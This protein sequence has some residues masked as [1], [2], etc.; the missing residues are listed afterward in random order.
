MSTEQKDIFMT[1]ELPANFRELPNTRPAFRQVLTEEFSS[2]HASIR[3]RVAQ[4]TQGLRLNIEYG[5][6]AAFADNGNPVI[7]QHATPFA[8]IESWAD[9]PLAS[10]SILNY[11]KPRVGITDI[12]SSGRAVNDPEFNKAFAR[13]ALAHEIIGHESD[14]ATTGNIHMFSDEALVKKNGWQFSRSDLF[15]KTLKEE[16]QKNVDSG[17]LASVSKYIRPAVD[18]GGNILPDSLRKVSA[19]FYADAAAY[20]YA[21]GGNLEENLSD[22]TPKGKDL[23]SHNITAFNMFP[24]TLALIAANVSKWVGEPVAPI[25]GPQAGQLPDLGILPS[26]LVDPNDGHSK[27]INATPERPGGIP[28]NILNNIVK[29]TTN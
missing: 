17:H 7:G 16:L 12:E 3:H 13:Y 26:T 15:L 18:E 20:L 28:R 21:K 10:R 9:L 24:K 1:D 14:R 4:G 23:A 6:D 25:R 19:E 8:A 5:K 27:N 29:P 11:G 2:W 22:F